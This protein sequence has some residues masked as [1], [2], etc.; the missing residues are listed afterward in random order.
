M[1]S[2]HRCGTCLDRNI[3]K[4]REC[5]VTNCVH[6]QEAEF[7]ASKAGRLWLLEKRRPPPGRDALLILCQ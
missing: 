1:I 2:L 3:L 7:A 5:P 4:V 6:R